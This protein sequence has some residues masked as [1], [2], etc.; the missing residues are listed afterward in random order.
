MATI[1]NAGDETRAEMHEVQNAL[2]DLAATSSSISARLIAL[3]ARLARLER[4][5]QPEVPPAATW[6][7]LAEP[8]PPPPA[9]VPSASGG[10]ELRLGQL[11][12][13][14]GGLFI[15]VVGIAYFLQ[16]SAERNWIGPFG[17]VVLAHLAGVAMISCGEWFRRRALHAFGLPLM[18]GGIAVLYCAGFAAFALYD[19]VP[20]SAAFALLSSV[21]AAAGV[22]AVRN[23]SRW[24]A[25]IGV[26]GGFATPVLLSDGGSSQ[27]A[28]MTYL[29]VLDAGVI[30]I[31]AFKQWRALEYLGFA[32]TWALVAGWT[33]DHSAP[34]NFWPTIVFVHL[35]FAAWAILPFVHRL[36]A[37][38]RP[39]GIDFGLSVPN[40]LIAFAFAA[41]LVPG[42]GATWHLALITLAHG[43]LFGA[44]AHYVYVRQRGA[45]VFVLLLTQA[46]FYVAVSVPLLM[47][48]ST[49]TAFW[50]VQAALMMWGAR[51]LGRR[52]LTAIALISAGLVAVR[53]L[54]LDVFVAAVS[55][56]PPSVAQRW[57]TATVVLVSLVAV[58]RLLHATAA[59]R[60]RRVV[61]IAGTSVLISLGFVFANIELLCLL[62]DHS[63][64]A[65][66]G[67][68][69]VLWTGVGTAMMVAG[70]RMREALLR[71]AALWVFAATTAKLFLLDVRDADRPHR[72]LAF[73]AL[74]T[75][76]VA[77]SFL[78]HR[79][80]G[81]LRIGP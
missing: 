48:V 42:H 43:A 7:D 63:G 40:S 34:E 38:R 64:S 68:V 17:R 74:G 76:L 58:A 32:F 24:L 46:L 41:H 11:G 39:R 3:Q 79:Y 6:A 55:D 22:L 13:L 65:R 47:P 56:V 71:H 77:S 61:A 28:F 30:G 26:V 70:F 81:R 21:T 25:I 69:S 72:M 31:A 44:L 2:A 57:V 37:S 10:F 36:R 78:Y 19:L 23:E 75:I 66:L 52:S 50:A 73:L 20:R 54:F 9:L 35:F 1:T 51:R 59:D 53:W 8:P 14:V 27:V 15:L 60:T 45:D 80:R 16:F 62:R 49:V 4:Q 12:L 67:A 5:P 33:S 29:L 18:G